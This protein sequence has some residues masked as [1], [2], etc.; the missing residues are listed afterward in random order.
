M[1][2]G[3]AGKVALVTASTRGLGFA[4]ARSL[5]SEGARVAVTGREQGAADAAAERIH[6]E[7][8]GDVTG[9]AGDLGDPSSAQ[10]LVDTTVARYGRLDAVICNS[11]PP[12]VGR[13]LTLDDAAWTLAMTEQ[14]L[15]MVRLARAAQP[16]LHKTCGALLFSTSSTTKQPTEAMALSTATRLGVT[17]LAKTLSLEFAPDVRVLVV[18]PGR[19]ATDRV[20]TLDQQR[21]AH[22][23]ST[24]AQV[25]AQSEATIALQRYGAPNEYGDVVAFLAS[26]RAS[27]MTGATVQVDGGLIRSTY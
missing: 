8:G 16:A 2:L 24:V 6:A 25:E 22:D 12:A 20:R 17:G 14:L 4:I 7:T 1:D 15:A 11:G 10:T 23:R 13:F 9:L 5:A 27:Y 19:F 21:A 18:A 3:L 26:P